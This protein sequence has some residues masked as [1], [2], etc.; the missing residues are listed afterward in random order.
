[1][2]TLAYITGAAAVFFVAAAIADYVPW[3]KDEWIEVRAFWRLRTA[4]TRGPRRALLR[5]AVRIL[6]R[7]LPPA[8]RIERKYHHDHH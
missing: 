8:S 2:T 1:M 4:H 5:L 7:A 6:D 3:G